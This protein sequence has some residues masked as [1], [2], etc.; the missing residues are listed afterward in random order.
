MF[1]INLRNSYFVPVFLQQHDFLPF[2]LT[3]II[4]I[5]A[6]GHVYQALLYYCCNCSPAFA[7]C[8]AIKIF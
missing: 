6:I 7:K 2:A 8:K 3:N 4:S 1:T 5:H